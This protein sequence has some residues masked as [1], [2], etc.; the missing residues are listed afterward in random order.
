M[1]QTSMWSGHGRLCLHKN[2][3]ST[4]LLIFSRTASVKSS[5]GDVL[6]RGVELKK[7]GP[8]HTDVTKHQ[9]RNIGNIVMDHCRGSTDREPTIISDDDDDVFALEGKKQQVC[10]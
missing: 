2:L 8:K 9:L 3:I 5:N 10:F 7:N 1:A 4:L 6:R